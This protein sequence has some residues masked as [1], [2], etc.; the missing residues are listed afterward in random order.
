MKKCN[1]GKGIRLT[2]SF[3]RSELSWPGNLM[4]LVTPEMAVEIRWF[5][6]AYEGVLSLSLL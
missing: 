6:S 3:L 1:C 2:L 5:K 4:E